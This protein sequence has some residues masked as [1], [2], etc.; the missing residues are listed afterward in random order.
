M[1]AQPLP[2]SF[3]EDASSP[4]GRHRRSEESRKRIVQAL[5]E[6][7]A[8]GDFFPSAEA[9]AEK[10]G[11]GLRSV[12]R[13]FKDMEGLRQEI[14]ASVEARCREIVDR[15]LNGDTW[16]AKLDDLVARRAQVFE[17]VMPYHRAGTAHQ[18]QSNLIKNN[19]VELN[20]ELRRILEKVVPSSVISDLAV[21]EGLDLVMSIQAWIRLRIDQG[22]TAQQAFTVMKHLVEKLIPHS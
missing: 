2:A 20:R 12:F 14:T 11:V 22:L 21:M 16:R 3:D 9:V 17:Q 19:Q 13:H 15:P 10:A 6:L 18:F 5:L 8:Y 1:S 7:V 4:D